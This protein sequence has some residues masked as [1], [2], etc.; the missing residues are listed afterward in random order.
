MRVKL[1]VEPEYL[2]SVLPRLQ[3]RLE[4]AGIRNPTV[5]KAGE[6]SILIDLPGMRDVQRIKRLVEQRGFVQWILVA[7][8]AMQKAAYAPTN[9]QRIYDGVVSELEK[10]DESA[11]PGSWTF[12]ELDSRL[13]ELDLVPTET[14]LRIWER[15][16]PTTAKVEKIPL[17]LRSN[18]DMAQVVS[19]DELKP[20]KVTAKTDA[21]TNPIISFEMK[22]EAAKRFADVTREYNANAENA[23]SV[24]LNRKRGWRIAILVDN[25]I[26]TAPAI[27]SE[28]L[29]GKG[30][31]SGLS[32]MAEAEDLAAKLRSG[33]LPVK[34]TIRTISVF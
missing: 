5:E 29:H 15:K 19:G 6:E 10:N 33:S 12:E 8:D 4:E 1:H 25:K 2:D 16:D 31:I 20:D 22:A 21:M 24:D 9:L 14:I 23:V 13:H 3:K 11:D 34:P 18:P 7:E 17:L 30:V 26:L 28:I 32:S 27:Q